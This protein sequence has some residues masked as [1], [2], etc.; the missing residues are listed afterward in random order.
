MR[1]RKKKE[2]EVRLNQ[3]QPEFSSHLVNSTGRS[4]TRRQSYQPENEFKQSQG[5]AKNTQ[6]MHLH[7]IS[8]SVSTQTSSNQLLSCHGLIAFYY[9]FSFVSS[10]FWT[11]YTYTTGCKSNIFSK[12]NLPFICHLTFTQGTRNKFVVKC[13]I[14]KQG[15]LIK[16]T[17]RL[18]NYRSGQDQVAIYGSIIGKC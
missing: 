10:S 15:Q 4:L 3:N 1:R 14:T 18:Q 7:Q 2:E 12:Q 8:K 5:P 17:K 6:Y 9:Q 11:A 16:M 13:P